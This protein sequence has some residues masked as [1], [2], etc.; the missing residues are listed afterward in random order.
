MRS[1]RVYF[2]VILM[3]S[4]V[5]RLLF[6]QSRGIQYDDAFSSLLA[7]RSFSEIIQGTAADTMP[8]LFY[9]LLHL[10]LQLG[11]ELWWLRLL[12][13]VFSLGCVAFLYLLVRALAGEKAG[14]WAAFLAGI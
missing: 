1:R 4:V 6:L 13:V 14:L 8:P 7:G 3:L 12:A 9:F 10:W 11:Q 2:I 5:L